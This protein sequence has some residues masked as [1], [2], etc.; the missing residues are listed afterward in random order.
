[1]LGPGRLF[2]MVSAVLWLFMQIGPLNHTQHLTVSSPEIT[3]LAQI[4]GEPLALCGASDGHDEAVLSDC[5]WCLLNAKP[6]L[7]EPSVFLAAS[8]RV[9]TKFRVTEP[10]AD[11]GDCRPGHSFRSRAPPAEV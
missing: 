3:E 2:A 9:V 10:T 8:L 1:M 6:I 5:G 7:P 11:A 4:L